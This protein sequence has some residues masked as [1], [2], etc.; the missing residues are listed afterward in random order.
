MYQEVDALEEQGT[1]DITTLPSGKVSIPSQWV[2][3][4]SNTMPMV[5]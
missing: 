3:F 5:L 4:A 1:W 2:Y